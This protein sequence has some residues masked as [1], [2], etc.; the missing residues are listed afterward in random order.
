[1]SAIPTLAV[2]KS[3]PLIHLYGDPLTKL[4]MICSSRVPFRNRVIRSWNHG[5]RR[6]LPAVLTFSGPE[7]ALTVTVTV[8]VTV[9]RLFKL[10]DD[11]STGSTK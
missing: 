10:H 7:R 2:E 5:V 1:M 4:C 8:T 3:D 9:R 11:I 6:V